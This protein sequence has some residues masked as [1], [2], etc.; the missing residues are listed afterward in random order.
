M[1]T[2]ATEVVTYQ[3]FINGEWVEPPQARL[4]TP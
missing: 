3:M 4:S 1:T 2:A